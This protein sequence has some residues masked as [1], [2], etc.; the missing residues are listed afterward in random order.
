MSCVP[1]QLCDGLARSND[2]VREGGMPPESGPAHLL[3][4]RLDE[5][6]FPAGHAISHGPAQGKMERPIVDDTEI[7]F[8]WDLL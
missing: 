5:M 6:R 4:I 3:S 7:Q 8:N 1:S 2:L